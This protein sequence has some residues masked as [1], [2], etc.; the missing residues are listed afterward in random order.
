[1]FGNWFSISPA[2]T[3]HSILIIL[4]IFA[5]SKQIN[6]SP[7]PFTTKNVATV[8]WNCCMSYGYGIFLSIASNCWI[9]METNEFPLTL[10]LV[11]RLT[12]RMFVRWWYVHWNRASVLHIAGNLLF[13]SNAISLRWF[14]QF[15][16]LLRF[17]YPALWL[18]AFLLRLCGFCLLLNH[19]WFTAFT[20]DVDASDWFRP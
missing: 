10:V 19:Y 7:V 8:R 13:T 9:C 18:S 2:V 20:D 5:V 1:M 4:N 14:L 6:E 16:P 11:F 17:C 12:D 15:L 3:L